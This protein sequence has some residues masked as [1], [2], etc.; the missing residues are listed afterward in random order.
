M[1]RILTLL[2]LAVALMEAQAQIIFSQDFESGVLDPMT[3]VDVDGKTV[4]PNVAGVAGPTFQV[5]Q[6]SSTNKSVVS[7]S[8]FEPVGQAD[9]WLISPPIQVTD[10]NTFLIWRAYSPDASY[11]DGYQVRIST[12]DN[13]I[14]SFSNL[15][16][17]VAAELTTW[18]QR[19]VKL[20]NYVGQTIY[21]AFRNNSNDK[22]LLFMDDIRVEVLKGNNAI[23]RSVAFEKYNPVDTEVPLKVTVENHGA[24]PITSLVLQYLVN[25]TPY[26]DSITGLNIAP[27]KTTDITAANSILGNAQGEYP[28]LVNI[29]TPNGVDDEDPV[30]NAG[31]RNL[32]FTADAAPKK[33]FVEEATGTWCIWCPRGAVNMDLIYEQ[34]HDIVMPVAVHNFDPMTVT[35]YDD[36]FST[37]VGGYPS[38]HVDRKSVDIDPADFGTNVALLQNRV[39]PTNVKTE[40]SWDAGTRTVSIKGTAHLPFPTTAND[41]RFACIITEDH[42]TGTDDGYA[43]ANIYSGGAQGVMGGFEDLPNPV[44][45]DQM[46]YNFVARALFGGFYGEENSIPDA[47]DANQEAEINYTYTVPAEFDETEMRVIVI[48][49][50]EQTGEVLNGDMAPLTGTVSVPV[51]PQGRFVAYPNPTSDVL[52]LEVDYQSDAQ[53]NMGIYDTY[54]RLIQSLGQLDLSSG[55]QLKQISVASLAS[56]N[57]ILQLR[58]KNAVTALPFTKI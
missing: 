42:V 3:A 14:A 23:L 19:S 22:Y 11:R 20:T 26:S 36:V 28:V 12:T 54:G 21:F 45:A 25:G 9:D 13:Q 57:Y 38:G 2:I 46:N 43:Q 35:E 47:L 5:V 17:N 48:V 55:K 52:N 53:I 8:W 30:D 16:L 18:T 58:N 31:S 34:Y 24:N 7:T 41:L 10:A 4:N 50:D 27:L 33:V 44:P 39:V 6:Q 49:L 56:G 29:S 15:A 37:T 40:T 1:K 51:I 32:Y